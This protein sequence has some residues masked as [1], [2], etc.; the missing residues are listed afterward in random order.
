MRS[1][2]AGSSR[3]SPRSEDQQSISAG[4]PPGSVAGETTTL[5]PIGAVVGDSR[6]GK[7]ARSLP[8]ALP[9]SLPGSF[10]PGCSWRPGCA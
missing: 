8:E 6:R 7:A 4:S 1:I 3:R 10:Q 9:V 5:V 2:D